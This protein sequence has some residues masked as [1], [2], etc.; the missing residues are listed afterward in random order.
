[1]LIHLALGKR[2]FLSD[3]EQPINVQGY[4]PVLGF[5]TFH[6][7]SGDLCYDQPYTG[8]TYHILIY[9]A[10]EI[11]T[12]AHH[13]LCQIQVRTNGIVVNDCPIFLCDNPTEET[14]A[15]VEND[16]YSDYVVLNFHLSGITSY[17]PVCLLNKN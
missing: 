9:Q 11:P 3:Y 6:T 8:R 7:I 12:L 14:H 2:P 15:I 4:E 13:L 5:K 17:F 1:M 10:S 16:K